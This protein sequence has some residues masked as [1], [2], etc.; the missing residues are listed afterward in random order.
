MPRPRPT[1]AFREVPEVGKTPM[2]VRVTRSL[3]LQAIRDAGID[4]PHSVNAVSVT[5]M[6]P[7]GGDYSNCQVD[8]DDDQQVVSV[9]Y[10]K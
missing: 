8:L 3:L 4:L 10:E 6:V 2:V 9:R 7:G 1:A 5:F